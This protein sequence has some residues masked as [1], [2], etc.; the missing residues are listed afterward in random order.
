[1]KLFLTFAEIHGNYDIS[2]VGGKALALSKLSDAG[3]RVPE[4]GCIPVSVYEAACSQPGFKESL[5]LELARKPFT[6][7][8]WEEIWDSS[9]RIRSKFLNLQVPDQLNSSLIEIINQNF[10]DCETA[11]RSSAPAEDSENT[12]FAGLHESYVGIR[13]AENILHHIK[14]V[15]ASLWSDRALLYRKELGL[16]ITDSKIAVVIQKFI[17]GDFSGAAFSQNPLQ[18]D[19]GVV[20]AVRGRGEDFVDGSKEPDRW[21]FARSSSELNKKHLVSNKQDALADETAR[22]V[23]CKVGEL[24]KKFHSP[25]DMEWTI[26]ENNL[27]L[28]QSRPI[29]TTKEEKSPEGDKRAWYLSLTKNLQELHNL[30]DVIENQVI[31]GMEQDAT[32]LKKFKLSTLSDN[33]LQEE[34]EKRKSIYSKWHDAYWEYCIPFAHGMRLFGQI[35]NDKIKPDDPYEFVQLLSGSN[36]ISI[37]RNQELIEIGRI[38]LK[39][40]CNESIHNGTL[41]EFE[42]LDKSIEEWLDR[43]KDSISYLKEG[44]DGKL[45]IAELAL[46]VGSKSGENTGVDSSIL[47]SA[48]LNSFSENDKKYAEELLKI[49]RASYAL[50]DNDNHYLE[51]IQT[52]V[53]SAE[54]EL[55]NRNLIDPEKAASAQTNT[56]QYQEDELADFAGNNDSII[57]GIRGKQLTGQPSSP[58]TAS[59]KARV[60]INEEDI[61]SIEENEILICDSISPVMTFVIPLVKAIVERRGGMLIHGAIIAREYGI[62]C[63]TGVSKATALISTGQQVTVDGYLGLVAVK[64]D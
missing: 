33:D 41:P 28:L 25:Q 64:L 50:R 6:E 36:L 2:Q 38:I 45:Q 58:G 62:P 44:L 12:S 16:N 42:D 23:F 20:E 24:E 34:Y 19:E 29:T 30:Q 22:L 17:E 53:N 1:M 40:K 21:F 9:L 39:H 26:S 37:K 48:Y 52:A 47:V 10:R 63:V 35:Y 31:P 27:Y 59:G 60:I 13:G 5:Q 57:P 55:L 14:L 43:Y 3:E 49:G 18:K 8:R 51:K 4:G 54:K 7:M 56:E 61:F 32:D 15:W 46:K 11:V